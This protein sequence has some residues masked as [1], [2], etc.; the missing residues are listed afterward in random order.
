MNKFFKRLAVGVL[1]LAM[2]AGLVAY[3]PA[4]T[5]EAKEDLDGKLVVIHTNDMHGHYEKNEEE[6][7]LGMSSVRALKGY[8]ERQGAN[9][10]LLDAGDFSQGTNLVNYYKGLD[11]IYFMNAAGYDAATLGNHEFD[12]GFDALLEMAAAADFP[13]LDANIIS[14]ETGEPYFGDNKIFTFS[15]MTVGVFGLDTP[16]TQTK[17]SP[18]NVKDVTFLDDAQL[19]ACAQEQVNELKAAGCD[20]V[21]CIGH[22]GVDEES[23]GRRSID[24]AAQVTGID[25]FI[26]G[27]S[28]TRIDGGMDVNGTKIVSTGNY[29][30]SIGVVIYDGKTTTASLVSDMFKFGGCPDMD[31]FVKTFADIVNEAYAGTFATTTSQLNG[32]RA[33]GV[34]TEETNL[35]DFAADAYKYIAQT[36]A[37][38][39]DMDMTIDAAIQNGGGIRATIEP[40][41]ISMDT[42]YT[43]FPYG[44]TISIVTVTG[45]EL[46]EAL[47]ASCFACPDALGGFPQVSGI[48]FTIDTTVPYAQGAQYPDST[49]F[50]PAAP[51]SRVTIESVGGKDF[52][53]KATYNI[54]VN[55]FMADGGDTYYVFAQSANVIETGVV[56]A[57]GLISY[58]NSLNGVIGDEYAASKGNITI[59]R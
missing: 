22:L 35:G 55:N 6:G 43:V 8:Y 30:E 12:F 25:L 49:Y 52:D 1:S 3:T 51:G 19:Y 14:K 57:E 39:N 26:D 15:D 31:A 53:L 38:E 36:Y 18:K 27:H 29:L 23:M 10:L 2:A 50:A 44:N 17:A 40:G 16:E 56:D 41:D 9:V 24:V 7:T 47:E 21:I 33:P 37:D 11:A 32:N 28:H 42:L 58:V 34:R 13:I 59:I 54:A 4:A 5:V 48:V 46:L 20:Y 45:E